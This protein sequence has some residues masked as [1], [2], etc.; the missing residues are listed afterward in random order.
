MGAID[1]EETRRLAV[2]LADAL[3]S[4]TDAVLTADT[5]WRLT[6]VNA[7]AERLFQRSR[8]ELVGKVLWETVPDFSGTVFQRE[9]ERVMIER[10]PVS[11][12]EF[13]SRLDLWVEIRV[14][15]SVEGITIFARDVT[16]QTVDVAERRR[17]EQQFLRARRMESIG[18]LA[19]GIAHDL[20]NLLMPILMGATLLK[21]KSGDA[22]ILRV[23]E[24]IERSANRGRDLVKQVL[25]FARGIEGSRDP[26]HLGEIVR[27]VRGMIETTFPRDIEL[28]VHVADHLQWTT[29]DPTQFNQVLLNLCVNARDAMPGGGVLTISATNAEIDEQY[30]LMHRGLIAGSFVVIEV[31]DTG[32]GMPPDIVDRLFEPFFTT[33]EPGRGKGLGLPTVNAIVQS[34]G[35]YVNVYSKVGEGSTF[36]IYLPADSHPDRSAQDRKAEL[37]SGDGELILIVDDEAAIL[38][39]TQQTLEAFGYRVITADD[40]AHAIAMYALRR[41]EIDVVVTDMMMP[42]MDGRALIAAL[43]RI[44]PAVKI[45][46]SSGIEHHGRTGKTAPEGVRYLLEKPYSAEVM[47]TT[48]AKVLGKARE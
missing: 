24:N 43:Q 40:G 26:V 31:V 14:F 15:P 41:H 45:I 42:I 44:D 12:T 16:V 8:E 19:G 4:V 46:A 23:A 39:I 32:T 11:F 22:Q 13:F 33:K 28:V 18:S 30:A 29:G 38:S 2:R 37:H 1:A 10:V 7:G 5:E 36:R 21:R 48:L 35:G 34:Y 20:N 17:I 9:F 6:Y 25:S 3:E 47:L 27:E